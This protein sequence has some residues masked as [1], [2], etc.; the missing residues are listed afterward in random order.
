[1]DLGEPRLRLHNL[2]TPDELQ[3]RLHGTPLSKGLTTGMT[4]RPQEV[5]VEGGAA[6]WGIGAG[7]TAQPG[8]APRG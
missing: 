3:S 6:V 2:R 8:G 5:E 1:M 4:A 7:T